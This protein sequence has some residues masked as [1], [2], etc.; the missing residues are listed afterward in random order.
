[1]SSPLSIIESGNSWNDIFFLYVFGQSVS[2]VALHLV[3]TRG[4]GCPTVGD[5]N[6]QTKFILKPGSHVKV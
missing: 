1:M 5:S 2:E 4:Q 6:H 3:A